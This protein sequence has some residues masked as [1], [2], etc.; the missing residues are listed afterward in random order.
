MSRVW[1]LAGFLG[2]TAVVGRADTPYP[3]DPPGF[4]RATVWSAGTGGYLFYRIPSAVV[5]AKGTLLVFCEGR[6]QPWGPKS[7]AGEIN[8]VMKRSADNGRTFSEQQVVWADGKNTCGN[9]TAVVDRET[10]TIVLV[11]T[12]NPGEEVEGAVG[13]GPNGRTVW[14]TR[15]KDDGA[16][17][18]TP[19][20][21]TAA[22][23]KDNWGWY[24]T[25][26]GIGIQLTRGEH[27][28][29]LVI[30]CNHEVAPASPDGGF[31]HVIYSDDHG[32]TW[33][34]GGDSSCGRTNESQVVELADGGVMQNMRNKGEKKKEENFKNRVIDVS[35]DGGE[36]FGAFWRDEALIEPICQGSIVRY[37]WPES[38]KSRIVFA[39]PASTTERVGMTVRV[40]Y[41][42]GKTWPVSNLVHKGWACYSSVVALPDGKVGLLFE[43]GDRARYE[44]MEFVRMSLGWISSGKDSGPP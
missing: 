6:R 20:E 21:I 8:V 9:P 13:T 40:S 35:G 23:K 32:E 27:K 19:R 39:N 22:V 3:G 16:T 24:A 34:L 2:L 17:W 31:S 36:T 41:D 25:G 28:G 10:G 11:M 15:S 5:T 18:E 37:S 7:D 29:R 4:E 38:G 44:R 12:H 30:P 14:V 43:A 1:I 42:E 33:K 26:P